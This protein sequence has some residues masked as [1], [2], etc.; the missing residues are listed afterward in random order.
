MRGFVG[1]G[2]EGELAA[3]LSAYA[4]EI[5]PAEGL[6]FTF[7]TDLHVTLKFLSEFSSVEFVRCLPA[8]N[9]LGPPPADSLSAGNV[10]LWPTVVALE[11]VPAPE[12]VKW[13]EE[14]NAVLERNGFIKERHPLFH[15]HI[16][17]ARLRPAAKESRELRAWLKEHGAKFK[18]R[19]VKLCSPALWQSQAEETGRRHRPFLSPLFNG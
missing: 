15:P 8:L 3:E 19:A 14:L 7:A 2:V 12:L 4:G 18:G 6:K 1:F 5:R 16:T 10:V 13:K 9:A 17:L 11:C